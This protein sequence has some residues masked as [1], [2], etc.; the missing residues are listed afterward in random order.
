[1][2]APTTGLSSSRKLIS[3]VTP[4]MNEEENIESFYARV[5]SAL[6]SEQGRYDLEFVFTDN[7][8]TDNTFAKL[9]ELAQRDSRVRVFRF[10]RNFGYQKSIYAGYMKARGDVAVQLD[11]DLQ[12]PPEL[13]P[14]FLRLWEQ[15]HQVVYGIR[16]NRDEPFFVQLTRRLFYWLVD[17]LSQDVLPRDAGDFRLIDRRII[18]ELRKVRDTNVY[19]RGRIAAMGFR[20][21]GVPYDRAARQKGTSK[22]GFFSMLSLAIDAIVSHSTVPLRIATWFGVFAI[23]AAVLAIAG[24]VATY[25]VTGKSWPGGFT[26]ITV[27]LLLNIG[28]TC[29]LLGVLGAYL[30]R[31]FEQVKTSPDPIMEAVLDRQE[32]ADQGDMSPPS[33]SA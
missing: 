13:I 23:A 22:F 7:H 3:I 1:M 30:G 17:A 8:S 14:E 28:A 24:Y 10:S 33:R 11:V 29:L 31:I 18:D 2:A 9:G 4:V 32:N 12:D 20:Q 25:Y 6:A 19:I 15:G 27:L 5:R 26:T 21:T 16:R